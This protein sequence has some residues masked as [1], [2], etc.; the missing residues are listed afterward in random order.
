MKIG[1]N[2]KFLATILSIVVAID[3]LCTYLLFSIDQIINGD[4]YNFGLQSNLGWQNGYWITMDSA[5]ISVFTSILLI[6]ISFSLLTFYSLKSNKK[7]LTAHSILF[8]LIAFLSVI[9]IFLIIKINTIVFT[10]LGQFGVNYDFQWT[11]HYYMISRLLLDLK[12]TGMAIAAILSSWTLLILINPKQ[13]L[14]KITSIILILGG[15]LTSLISAIFDLLTGVNMGLGLILIGIIVWYITSQQYIKKK[16]LTTQQTITYRY[17]ERILAKFKKFKKIIYLPQILT[18]ENN[19]VLILTSKTEENLL[20]KTLNLTEKIDKNQ[21]IIAPGNELTKLFE[22]E[23]KTDFAK[24]ELS[25]LRTKLPHLIVEN[26]EIATNFQIKNQKNIVLAEFENSIFNDLVFEEK[27]LESIR[28]FGCPLSSAIACAIAKATGKYTTI[29]KY[30]I[31]K[32][33]NT[34]NVTFKLI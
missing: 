32:K 10:V 2:K 28:S 11:S 7:A 30:E 4:L 33:R 24:I 3:I 18:K 34:T 27:Y 6:A 8:L 17:L 5:F 9:S 29:A 19:T 25:Y 12:T 1:F 13:R 22:N 26:L 20:A 23:L 31:D 15:T 16:I 14:P 21:T